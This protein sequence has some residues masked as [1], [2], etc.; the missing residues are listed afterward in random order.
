[1]I[2]EL[3]F[4]D[5]DARFAFVRAMKGTP[6]DPVHHAE[7]DVWIHTRM[8]ADALVALPAFR[9]LSADERGV[10]WTAAILHDVGKPHTTRT[11][12]SGKITSQGHSTR[13]AVLARQILWRLGAPFASR[14]HAVAI[15]RHHQA[16]FWLL[17]REDPRSL[18]ARIS[19]TARCDLLALVAEADARGRECRDQARILENIELF[20]AYAEEHGC[21][22]A[23]FAFASDHARFLHLGGRLRDPSHAPHEAFRCEVV[24]MSGLPGSGK[25]HWI[26][27]NLPGWPVVSLDRIRGELGVGPEDDQG[28]VIQRAREEAR[29]HLRAGRSFAWSA[30]NLSRRIRAQCIRLFA[31]YDARVRIAYVEVP[32]ATL[33]A[34]NRARKAVVPDRAIDA[35]LEHWEV[36]DR[37]EAHEVTYAIR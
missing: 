4:P 15:V 19:L 26:A 11:D 27:A 10:A 22:A 33:R 6:Q 35:M 21:L 18:V 29:E 2:P 1:M 3:T 30:T 14:E 13:G 9:A 16:P 17:E 25:D 12:E 23:P 37:S 36:P 7:G 20:R 28:A 31:D 24:L 8:V 32:E 5:L 34:Q